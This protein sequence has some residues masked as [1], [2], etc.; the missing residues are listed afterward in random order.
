MHT[1]NFPALGFEASGS[2]QSRG[3][4]TM[5]WIIQNRLE[6][7]ERLTQKALGHAADLSIR[8]LWKEWSLTHPARD[9]QRQAGRG[10]TPPCLRPPDL[11]RWDSR[12]AATSGGRLSP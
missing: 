4:G 12:E 2:K 3:A 11:H 9:R 8:L 1:P 7:T 5:A 6:G 10:H